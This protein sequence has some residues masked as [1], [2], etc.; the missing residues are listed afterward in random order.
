MTARSLPSDSPYNRFTLTL[1]ALLACD[2]MVFVARG[3]KKRDLFQA[4]IRGEH[5]LPVRR[6]LAAR[7]NNVAMPVTCFY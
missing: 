5:D 4:A 3:Q 2:E 1:P 7:E 6:L